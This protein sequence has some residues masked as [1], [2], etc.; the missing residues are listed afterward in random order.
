[1]T[2]PTPK[3]GSTK[4]GSEDDPIRQGLFACETMNELLSRINLRGSPGPFQSIADAAKLTDEGKAEEAKSCLRSILDLQGLE[5]RV[6]LWVWSALREL[7]VQPD[8][9]LAFEV[10]GVVVEIPMQDAYDSVA[11]YKDGTARYLNF[12]GKAI[13]W[14]VKDP[15]VLGLCQ[16]L[17]GSAA[18]AGS[19]AKPRLS[20]ALPKSG[21]QVTLLTRSGMFAITNPPMTIIKIAAGLMNELIRRANE[22]K[23]ESPGSI[24][25]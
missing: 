18:Q 11:G 13:F 25:E 4:L 10:L 15:T 21:M 20:V 16:A 2:M 7:S 3:P 23:A 22:Q 12:S 5:T 14:D 6:E 19:Q 8:A 17:L 9:K 24:K 1:M